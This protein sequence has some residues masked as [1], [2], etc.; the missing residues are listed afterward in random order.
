M[1]NFLRAI[2]NKII[3]Y[4]FPAKD[5]RPDPEDPVVYAHL[6]KLLWSFEDAGAPV[7]LLREGRPT[8]SPK[9]WADVKER[10]K[11]TALAIPAGYACWV[12]VYDGPTGKGFVVNYETVRKKKTLRKSINV[13]PEKGREQDWTEVPE[14]SPEKE[15]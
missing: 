6:E 13:G 3:G 5:T 7:Q 10:G 2:W 8:D 9:A 11:A 14:R 15:I 12:D 4:F 1:L